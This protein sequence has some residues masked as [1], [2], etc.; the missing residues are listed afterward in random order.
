M[1]LALSCGEWAD[2]QSGQALAAIAGRYPSDPYM[3]GAVMSSA[4]K[5][6]AAF[7]HDIAA[8]DPKTLS[9]YREPLLRQSLAIGDAATISVLIDQALQNAESLA[10]TDP[11][12]ATLLDLQRMGKSVAFRARRSNNF[13][14]RNGR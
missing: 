4:L 9:A 3:R 13:E 2:R 12:D 5:H 8:G 10:D 1:Q 7:A 14:I 6:A 11:L